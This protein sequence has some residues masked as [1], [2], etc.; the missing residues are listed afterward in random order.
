MVDDEKRQAA[1]ADR[2]AKLSGEIRV[3]R[4]NLKSAENEKHQLM[5][6]AGPGSLLKSFLVNRSY[7]PTA[8][9]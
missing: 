5:Q 8:L 2:I 1:I 7:N 9:E 6:K 3:L 4:R